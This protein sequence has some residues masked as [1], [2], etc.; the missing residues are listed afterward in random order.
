MVVISMICGFFD[1]R[2][3]LCDKSAV[4]DLSLAFVEIW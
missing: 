2:F 4:E 3:E 1:Y